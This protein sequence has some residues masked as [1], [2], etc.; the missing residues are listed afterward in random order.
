[1]SEFIVTWA[2]ECEA[3]SSEEAAKFAW[4]II[5]DKEK[6]TATFLTVK[7]LSQDNKNLRMSTH[8]MEKQ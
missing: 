6:N 5:K 3:D 8:N 2:I 4:E 1:M 7:N